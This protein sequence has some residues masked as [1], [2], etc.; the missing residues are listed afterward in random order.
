M[1]TRTIEISE[2]LFDIIEDELMDLYGY[3]MNDDCKH[4]D[5]CGSKSLQQLRDAWEDAD[6]HKQPNAVG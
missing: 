2:E 6:E 5:D 4:F 1:K 3:H